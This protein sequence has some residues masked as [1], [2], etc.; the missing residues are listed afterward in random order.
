MTVG[1]LFIDEDV[2]NLNVIDVSSP[3]ETKANII[4]KFSNGLK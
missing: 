4:A 2:F 3:T 1:A